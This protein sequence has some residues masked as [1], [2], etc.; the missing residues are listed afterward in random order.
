M[1]HALLARRILAPKQTPVMLAQGGAGTTPVPFAIEPGA[2]Y[3]ATVAG[4]SGQTK[5]IGI[6]AQ[7][8]AR[9]STDDRNPNEAAG[10]VTFCAFERARAT[11][12]IE[13]R[14]TAL[15]WGLAVFRVASGIWEIAR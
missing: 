13:A 7:V 1:A 11:L 5:G 9:E 10:A 14:G 4:V 3:V 6:R 15:V 8:G 2:C 12:Q